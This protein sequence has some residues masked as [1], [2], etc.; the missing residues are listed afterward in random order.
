MGYW[1]KTNGSQVFTSKG[2]LLN[3]DQRTIALS[4]FPRVYT[5]Q[6][7]EMGL[8]RSLKTKAFD[9]FECTEEIYDAGIKRWFGLFYNNQTEKFISFFEK[10]ISLEDRQT[11]NFPTDIQEG[12]YSTAFGSGVTPTTLIL[13]VNQELSNESGCNIRTL[14]NS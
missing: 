5:M 7:V 4:A 2:E 6:W 12:S 14:L 3:L 10:L 8:E 11:L 13:P 9:N 1:A